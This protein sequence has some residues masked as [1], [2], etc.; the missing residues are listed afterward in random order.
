MR[1]KIT[2][3]FWMVLFLLAED[4]GFEPPQTESESGV[5]PLHKSSVWGTVVLY[6]IFGKSQGLFCFFDFS[7]L[8]GSMRGAR[9]PSPLRGT[10]LINAGARVRCVWRMVSAATFRTNCQLSI[11]N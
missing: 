7:F 5:L 8:G 3:S 11:V 2:P 10:L 4:E 1:I 9:L 6:P